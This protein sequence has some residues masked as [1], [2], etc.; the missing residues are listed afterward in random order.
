L[1]QDQINAG[2]DA[3]R[4]VASS[5]LPRT[6]QDTPDQIVLAALRKRQQEL[7][8]EQ[9]ALL[10]QLEAMDSVAAARKAPDLFQESSDPGQDNQSEAS[11]ILNARISALK[12]RIQQ[13]NARPRQQ[14][15]GPSAQAAPY[16]QYVEN[17]RKKIELLGTE[18]Y[19]PEARGTVYGKLRLTVY[20]KSNGDL[21][22]V[23]ID[24]PSEHA[25]LNL[26]AQRIVQLAA[27][28]APLPPEI[29]QETDVLAVTRTWHFTNN[30]LST[31]S[32]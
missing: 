5:P 15:V 31:E 27:P 8:A 19:P 7:E 32:Q 10:T 22:R 12:E 20:I 4:G 29:A 21:D 25:V 24:S 13:Y 30:A 3:D 9:Q 2:G 23:Q 16:A 28:F 18:H 11:L 26:A 14:F 17:W 6:A 1:A